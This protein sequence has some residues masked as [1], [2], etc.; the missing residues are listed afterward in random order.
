MRRMRSAGIDAFG[1]D[2][3]L[4]ELATPGS[5]APDEVVISVYA[6]SIAQHR[7]SNPAANAISRARCERSAPTRTSLTRRS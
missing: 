3:R 4:L 7:G 5:P 6:P 1:D 2:V